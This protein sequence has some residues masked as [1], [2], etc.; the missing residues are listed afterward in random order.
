MT[1][2]I[3][4][5]Q[6]IVHLH[7]HQLPGV[8]YPVIY[9][10]C[11]KNTKIYH[12]GIVAKRGPSGALTIRVVEQTRVLDADA[13]LHVRDKFFFDRPDQAAKRPAWEFAEA[14]KEQQDAEFK[15]RDE[16]RLKQQIIQHWE[17][18][19]DSDEIAELTGATTQVIGLT[20]SAEHRA[21][22]LNRP[23]EKKSN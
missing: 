4:T 11:Q 19:R 5:Q 14:F 21:G 8:G 1:T 22:K 16:A 2:T 10:P 20:L 15:P 7:D 13:V 23:W 9:Y 17:G 6:D 18:G 3:M 12:P